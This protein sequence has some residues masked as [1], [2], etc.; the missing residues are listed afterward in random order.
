[1]RGHKVFEKSPT[2]TIRKMFISN[3][4]FIDQIF[5]VDDT[6]ISDKNMVADNNGYELPR[7]TISGQ[8]LIADINVS[9]TKCGC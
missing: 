8:L 5:L 4:S 3:Q 7:I 6:N 1:M 9:A 2:G